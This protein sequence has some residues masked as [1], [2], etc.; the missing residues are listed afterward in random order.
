M[1]R[2]ICATSTSSLSWVNRPARLG[3]MGSF[4]DPDP[5]GTQTICPAPDLHSEPAMDPDLSLDA[6]F[7][8]LK[9]YKFFAIHV[10]KLSNSLLITYTFSY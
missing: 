1:P 3:E 7:L 4:V 6:T 8:T 2:V 10:L 5:A 9:I